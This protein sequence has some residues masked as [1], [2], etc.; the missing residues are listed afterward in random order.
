MRI[1]IVEDMP[2]LRA[3]ARQVV[4][5]VFGEGVEIVEASN[6]LEGVQLA[7]SSAPDLTIMDIS[8]PELNGVKAAEEIW[9]VNKQARILFWSQY[10][11]EAYVRTLGRIVP[12]EAIHGYLLKGESD[13]KLAFAIESV[14]T[15]GDPY[16]DPVVQG[17]QNRLKSKDDS[18][19]DTEYETLLDVAIGMTDR[20]I[21]QRRHISVRGVQNRLSMLLG[22]L[23]KGQD[24]HLRESAGME[25]FNPR[26][27]IVYEG[28]RRGLVD[29]DDLPKLDNEVWDWL[30]D[31]FDYSN[32]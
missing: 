11:R 22:K 2:A 28:I 31:E 24:A 25:I 7:K 27:R 5:K 32:I 16:I 29:P 21:A 23:V 14:L 17:V 26:T 19:S 20:A 30:E 9:E 3:H 10:H 12:D 1:L 4:L 8:M 6:G 18:L 15:K 13:D